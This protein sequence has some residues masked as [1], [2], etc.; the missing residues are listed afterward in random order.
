MPAKPQKTALT[1]GSAKFYTIKSGLDRPKAAPAALKKSLVGIRTSEFHT[2][3][4]AP[5]PPRIPERTISPLFSATP[6]KS[7]LSASWNSKLIAIAIFLFPLVVFPW[8][9]SVYEFPKQTFLALITGIGLIAATVQSWR[10]GAIGLIPRHLFIPLSIAAAAVAAVSAVKSGLLFKGL[11]GVGG[12]EALSL[13][14]TVLLVIWALLIF[15]NGLEAFALSFKTLIVSGSALSAVALLSLFKLNLFGFMSISEFNP[16]GSVTDAG[17]LAA[18]TIVLAIGG[19]MQAPARKA[20]ILYGIALAPP[21]VLLLGT[22]FFIPFIV[23]VAGLAVFIVATLIRGAVPKNP[24]PL[25]ILIICALLTTVLAIFPVTSFVQTPVEIGPAHAETWSIVKQTLGRNPL[26]GSGPATFRADYLRFRS[27]PVLQTP[28]WNISF[29]WGSSA[30]LTALATLGWVG[31]G[32]LFFAVLSVI[33]WYG[34]HILTARHFK[35]YSAP[36]QL[37]ES[38]HYP[39]QQTAAH[40]NP[41]QSPKNDKEKTAAPVYL[42]LLSAGAA[43]IAAAW[44][45]P[46][47]LALQFFLAT[48]LGLMLAVSAKPFVFRKDAPDESGSWY[49]ASKTSISRSLAGAFIVAAVL[50]LFLIQSLRTAAEALAVSAV[51]DAQSDITASQIRLEKAVNLTP[52]NSNYLRL[53]SEAR[54][55]ILRKRFAQAAENQEAELTVQEVRN[56]L[57]GVL[58]PAHKTAVIAPGEA[59]NWVTLGNIY[60]SAAPLVKDAAKEAAEKFSKALELSPADPSILVNLSIAQSLSARSMTGDDAGALLDSAE[61]NLRSALALRPAYALAHLELARLL[62]AKGA[63]DEALAAYR[64]AQSL[65]EDNAA[66][67]Y[68][69]GIYLLEN[70]R[71]PEAQLELEQAVRAAPNF[72]N[73]RWFLA[74]IYEE[75]KNITAAIEQLASIL[76]LNPE[77]ETAQTRLAELQGKL[78]EPL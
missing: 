45:A 9:F 61:K 31:S 46:L 60:L 54:N 12:A 1:K 22:G 25:S 20:M 56:L 23:L 13:L 64:Q 35:K 55:S 8:T 38:L 29:D 21:I 50:G 10:S 43:F 57:D 52:Y 59:V 66:F 77:S 33:G 11:L 73:A 44:L 47:P 28:F 6:Q 49:P 53:L 40:F 67:R 69:I 14:S 72:S 68:E 18:V 27:L 78:E 17:I 7:L 3:H 76:E 37:E 2:R 58:A 62:T 70:N 34:W 15:R 63:A 16:A 71:L 41:D 75:Q 48:I 65:M 36:E 30:A 24:A 74:Q 19:L 4:S 26:A 42:A 5:P 39:D 51:K 32:L